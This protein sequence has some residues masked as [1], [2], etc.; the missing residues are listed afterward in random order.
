M[1]GRVKKYQLTGNMGII[2][3]MLKKGDM[4]EC[5]DNEVLVQVLLGCD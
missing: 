3:K 5:S 4:K 1:S 2:I